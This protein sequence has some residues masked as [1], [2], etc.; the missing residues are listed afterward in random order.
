M[1]KEK[2]HIGIKILFIFIIILVLIILYGRYINPYG[3]KVKEIAITN[4]LLPSSYNGLKI[5][6]F[7]DL[8][9]N[10]E[11]DLDNITKE[12]NKLNA[13][14]II[15]TGDLFNHK[16]SDKEI[17]TV[18]KY[19]NELNC[20]LK[21]IAILG[22]ND[23][24]Y[25]DTIKDIYANTDFILLDNE[26]TLLYYENSTPINFIGITDNVDENLYSNDYLNITLIH[27]PDLVTKIN[28]PSLVF[29]GHSLGGQIK[30]PFIG[31]LIKKEGAK[32]YLDSHYK[33]N[34]KDLYISNGLG[35]E[36]ITFRLFN[37]PSINLY[38]LYNK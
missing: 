28:K 26:N 25:L 15:F 3:F 29:A 31:G 16:P 32:T 6:Q 30:I 9:Y 2:K 21:K 18:T 7:S 17:E 34:D 11:T 27:Q 35:N 19:L 37:T 13:D 23:L 33:I 24:K 20:R 12:L 36:K 10:E 14:I 5:A 1:E 4:N 22:D 8:F 38:R